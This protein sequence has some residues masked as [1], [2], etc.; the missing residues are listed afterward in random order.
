MFASET[1]TAR[2]EELRRRIGSGIIL[3]PGNTFSPY[4]AAENA[5]PFRQDSTFRYYFGLDRPDTVGIIDP[6]TGCDALYG[7]DLSVEDIV[8]TGPQPSLAEL[9]ARVGV[10]RTYTLRQLEEHIASA[11]RQGRTVHYL[12]PYRGETKL[13]LCSLLGLVPAVLYDRMSVELMAAVAEMRE[14]KSA[15]E[16]AEIEKAFHTGYDMHTTAMKMCRPGASEH[17]IAAAVEGAAR[18]TGVAVSFPSIVTQHGETLHNHVTDGI[19]EPGRLLLVDAG[20]EIAS[21]YC[22]D[23]TRTYPVSGRFTD[24]Q[25]EIYEIVL[26]AHDRTARNVKPGLR[27]YEDIHLAAYRTLAEGLVSAGLIH[28]PADDAVASGAMTMFMPHGL[29]HGMGLDV[30]DC[31]SFGERSGAFDFAPFAERMAAT[32]TCVYRRTWRVREGTVLSDEPGI[33]FIPALIDKCRAEG[34]YRGIVDYDRL[35]AYRDFGGIR[36]ED[37]LIVT[38]DGCRMAGGGKI[39]VSV[40]ELEE[41]LSREA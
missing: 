15:E 9:G 3:L 31:E 12:P 21:G 28:G 16:I 38:S 34:L 13:Q 30:H 5:Y 25:R 36:I 7:N 18:K 22:S 8:W 37:D 23:H 4:N 11:L 27:Y 10:T 17:E 24:R 33:Y 2:R 14:C 35:E 1:Y 32:E 41:F 26:A 20:G 40:S 39:P 6:E 19:L 29:G